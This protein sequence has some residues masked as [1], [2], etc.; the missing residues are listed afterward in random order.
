MTEKKRHKPKSATRMDGFSRETARLRYEKLQN[1]ETE[2]SDD[3]FEDPV[4]V[5][6]K[7]AMAE[8]Q[9]DN[10]PGKGKLLD[11]KGYIETPEHLRTAYHILKNAG[12]IPEEVRLKKEMELMRQKLKDCKSNAEREKLSKELA[13]ISQQFNFY[14][15]YNKKLGK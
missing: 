13:D 14:M 7:A 11:L 12:F 4:E 3:A 15:E 5:K 10:L 9:F 2:P 8:G 6:I 1:D